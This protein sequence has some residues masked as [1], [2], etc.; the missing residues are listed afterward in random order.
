[1]SRRVL[2][3]ALG[4]GLGHL[5]RGGRFLQQQGLAADA[6]I[7]S[8]SAHANDARLSSGVAVRQV[9]AG[10]QHDVPALR[11]WLAQCIDAFAP[12]C[13]CVDSFPAGLLGELGHFPTLQGMQLWHVARLL[14][15][16]AYAPLLAGAPRY[17]LAWRIEPL[18]AEQDAWLMT[19]ADEVRDL[20]L[21]VPAAAIVSNPAGQAYWLV[22]HSGP[23]AEVQE[24]IAY[25]RELRAVEAADGVIVVASLDPPGNLPTDCIAVDPMT[26]PTLYAGAA[27]IVCA[28]GFN[29]VA[30]TE[31]WHHKR[32]LL[33]FPRRF[34]DQ[35]ARAARSHRRVL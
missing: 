31:V 33:P 23:G 8:A 35:F 14:R 13:I 19:Q 32:H 9:P 30:E 22:A 5:V 29:I 15:W 34:D 2:Y 17:A 1:M 26:L 18:H 16:P 12:T 3:Y 21:L 27:R 4:G 24:L 10:L 6:L 11:D 20:R 25:A 28:A 7:L